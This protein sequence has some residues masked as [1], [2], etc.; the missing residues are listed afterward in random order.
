GDARILLHRAQAPAPAPVAS[1]E[2]GCDHAPAV[3]VQREV[4]E[5]R[6]AGDELGARAGHRALDRAV[7]LSRPVLFVELLPQ[8]LGALAR[9]RTESLAQPVERLDQDLGVAVAAQLPGD[10]A[11]VVVLATPRV[12]ADRVPDQPQGRAD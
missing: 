7:A 1:M 4:I 9:R 11:I 6:P 3:S 12:V 10:V 8:S 2:P 5:A